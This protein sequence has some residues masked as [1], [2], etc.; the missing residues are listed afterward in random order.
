M[1]Q[2]PV[3][4]GLEFARHGETCSGTIPFGELAR[5][6]GLLSG[7][8]GA[9]RYRVSGRLSEDGKAFLHI[10]VDGRLPL[11]CQR[12]LVEMEYPLAIDAEVELVA[13]EAALEARAEDAADAVVAGKKMEVAS[14]VEEEILLGIPL[15]PRHDEG[16]C[17]SPVSSGTGG[18][19]NAF[20]A[21]AA[22][23]QRE[24]N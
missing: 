7:G 6:R 23:K 24:M 10:A 3:I 8:A 14:L 11:T 17:A 22:L 19:E 1:S 13:D 18:A 2:Q 4:N 20:G 15:S 12:C 9:V 21:L 5:V 16:A